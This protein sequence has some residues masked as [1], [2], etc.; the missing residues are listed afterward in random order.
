MGRDDLDVM[1]YSAVTSLSSKGDFAA[2]IQ[3]VRGITKGLSMPKKNILEEAVR[4][5]MQEEIVIS[6]SDFD[7]VT[8]LIRKIVMVGYLC[9]RFAINPSCCALL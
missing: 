6:R 9:L 2:F 1:R 5:T 4:T 7:M 3:V 8:M